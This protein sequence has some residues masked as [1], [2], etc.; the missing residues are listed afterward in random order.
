MQSNLTG[1]SKSTDGVNVVVP[2]TVIVSLL[3]LPMFTAPLRV[4]PPVTSKSPLA[5]T[6]V[7][8]IVP[9]ATTLP[10]P[11]FT[12][13]LLVAIAKLPVMFTPASELNPTTDRAL[14]T[15]VD[16]LPLVVTNFRYEVP[17]WFIS[18]AAAL[19]SNSVSEFA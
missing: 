8:L 9:A 19:L 3:A 17:P 14:P 6:S 1:A 16:S 11:A 13:N 18:N 4:V 10:E 7:P 2:A 12:V 5:V 15:V